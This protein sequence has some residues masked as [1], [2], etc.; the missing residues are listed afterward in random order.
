MIRIL[1]LYLGPG[2]GG[3]VFSLIQLLENLNNVRIK[4]YVLVLPNTNQESLLRISNIPGVELIHMK[5]WINN[6]LFSTNSGERLSF[7]KSLK[8]NFRFF[9]AFYNSILISRIIL[10][11]KINLVH[12]NIELFSE[13][14]L[15]AFISGRKHIW[16]IRAVI[17][18]NGVVNHKLG[19]RFLLKTISFFSSAII[20]NSKATLE[21]LKRRIPEKK[22]NLVYNGISPERFENPKSDSGLRHQYSISGSTIIVGGIGYVSRL[23]GALEFV[24]VAKDV[25][26]SFNNVVFLYIGPAH[27]GGDRVTMQFCDNFLKDNSLEKRVIYTG[28][29]NDIEKIIS[30]IDIFFQPMKNGSWS[31]VVMEAMAAGK[32]VVA[33]EES[34]TSELIDNTSTGLIGCNITECADCIARLINDDRL[35]FRLGSK[36]KDHVFRHFSN[37]TA[38]R[39][40]E[41]IYSNLLNI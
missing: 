32:P 3:P 36:A 22:L 25:I 10:K 12:S 11:Y 24:E 4:A 17:G 7:I 19:E 15:A 5:I 16:H 26:N 33:F 39:K 6:W 18:N 28:Y 31:R 9:R 2:I 21:P 8:A 1:F 38:A 27:D 13:G 41:N 23:K 29:R 20:A 34:K 35:R 14:A 40:I 37:K 30:E